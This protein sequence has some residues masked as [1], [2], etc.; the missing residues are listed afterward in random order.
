MLKNKF[1]LEQDKIKKSFM[2]V[3]QQKDNETQTLQ[4]KHQETSEALQI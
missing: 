3:I 4:K 2:S 1:A